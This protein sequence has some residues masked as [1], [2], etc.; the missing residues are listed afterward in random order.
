MRSSSLA[1]PAFLLLFVL[2]GCMTTTPDY[3]IKLMSSPD[4]TVAVPPECPSWADA[5]TGSPLNNGPSPLFG[6]ASARNLAAQVARPEDL[7]EGRDL[8]APDAVA[9]SAA[10]ARYRA[11]KTTPLINPG[12]PAPVATTKAEDSRVGGGTIK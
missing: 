1:F 9:A 5:E 3:R 8:G 4:G 12:A 7:I 6:C 10:V 11:G 2:G